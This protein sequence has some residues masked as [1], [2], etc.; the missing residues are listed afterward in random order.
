MPHQKTGMM[1]RDIDQETERETE[2][3]RE[4]IEEERWSGSENPLSAHISG[5]CSPSVGLRD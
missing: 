4:G 3:V 5:L 2:R 1:E